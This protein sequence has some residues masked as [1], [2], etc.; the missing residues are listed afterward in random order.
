MILDMLDVQVNPYMI[1]ALIET[2]LV[3]ILTI[4]TAKKGPLIFLET[5]IPKIRITIPNTENS[6]ILHIEVLWNLR[7]I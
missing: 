3:M 5:P 7:A 4:R 1:R 2:L 6:H